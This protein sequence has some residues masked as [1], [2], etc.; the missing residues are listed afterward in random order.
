MWKYIKYSGVWI[1]IVVNPFHWQF[2][3]K[4]NYGL[5]EIN[6]NLFDNSLHFGFIWI[7]I[8]IDDGRW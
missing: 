6:D 7:R 4:K 1:G 8:I 2:G 3:W 5:F